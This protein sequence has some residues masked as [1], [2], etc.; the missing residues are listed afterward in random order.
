MKTLKPFSMVQFAADIE[1]RS[2][3]LENYQSLIDEWFEYTDRT[4]KSNI[5]K[6][7]DEELEIGQVY[8]YF[9]ILVGKF[10]NEQHEELKKLLK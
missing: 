5:H 7:E 10:T 2:E 8:V 6:H 9:S 1:V 3:E 4:L